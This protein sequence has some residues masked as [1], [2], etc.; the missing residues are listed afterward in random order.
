MSEVKYNIRPLQEEVLKIFKV[1][2]AICEKHGLRYYAAYGTAL[3]AIRHHGFIPWDDDF[4]VAMPRD[5]YERFRKMAEE[6]LP[7]RYKYCGWHNTKELSPNVYAK[8]QDS[9]R[10]AV[11]DIEK[12]IGRT[13][14]HGV[15][16]D[17]FPLDGTPG[18][19]WQRFKWM[20]RLRLLRSAYSSFF[21]LMTKKR[22]V[23]IIWRT[24]GYIA[25]K[26]A[27]HAKSR[28]DFALYYDELSRTFKYGKGLVGCVISP[29]GALRDLSPNEVYGTPNYVAFE[30]SRIAVPSN[31]HDYLTAIYG[32]YM[33]LPP[34]GKRCPTH[35]KLP[36]APWKFG[37]T[38][39]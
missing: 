23:T 26:F 39:E 37:P 10:V 31:S 14:P 18:T 33:T 17:I 28:Y 25:N 15:Y 12:K 4:D 7:A 35:A 1:F 3:G 24:A 9:D 16:I 34:V 36:D 11:L 20:L 38:A 19:R 8:I 22:P 13:L 32:D 21:G 5:D 27:F 29:Y 30:G 6:V 2:A